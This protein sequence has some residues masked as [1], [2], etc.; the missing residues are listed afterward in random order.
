MCDDAPPR[1]DSSNEMRTAGSES[2]AAQLLLSAAPNMRKILLV[3]A[4]AACGTPNGPDEAEP[5]Q[6][7][8][9]IEQG[10]VTCQSRTDTGYR[11]GSSFTITVVTAD[12]KPVEL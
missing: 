4:I 3:C 12:G 11:N 6:L 8:T 2:K 5:D 7:Y 10:L 9:S 1:A